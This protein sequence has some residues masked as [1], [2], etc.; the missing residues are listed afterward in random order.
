M[1]FTKYR[2][3]MEP[4]EISKHVAYLIQYPAFLIH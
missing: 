4:E 2:I 1:S 3:S